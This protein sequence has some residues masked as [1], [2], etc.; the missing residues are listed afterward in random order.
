MAD[1][2]AE[3]EGSAIAVIYAGSIGVLAS[4]KHWSFA[5]RSGRRNAKA[6]SRSQFEGRS[7]QSKCRAKA[8]G[9]SRF[10]ATASKARS[11]LTPLVKIGIIF[12]ALGFFAAFLAFGGLGRRVHCALKRGPY[13]ACFI[14][15][16]TF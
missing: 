3:T 2:G 11:T 6:G 4:D 10:P 12:G 7:G 14:R 15:P 5:E 13:S 9:C 16:A 8:S 1:Y